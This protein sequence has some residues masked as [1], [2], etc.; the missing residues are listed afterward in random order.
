LVRSRR[1]WPPALPTTEPQ[2]AVDDEV[3]EVELPQHIGERERLTSLRDGRFFT[4]ELGVDSL[5]LLREIGF[6]PLGVVVGASIY[7]IGWQKQSWRQNR[8]VP[9]LTQMMYNARELMM[10]RA[11][12]EARDLGADGIINV[13][14]D[15]LYWDWGPELAE[16]LA[17]GTAVR[18]RDPD[19]RRAPETPPFTTG[20]DGR[21]PLEAQ[22]RR[23]RAARVR[24]GKLRLPRR[25]SKPP[26][27]AKSSRPKPGDAELHAGSLL[28]P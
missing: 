16:F 14:V 15:I 24:D 25:S 22:A 1:A 18:H 6:E 10:S 12:D 8:E 27:H 11:I 5:L 7:H 13:G 26:R 19:L 23:F 17:F 4:S 21:G 20:L 2:G 9:E 28:S 3:G